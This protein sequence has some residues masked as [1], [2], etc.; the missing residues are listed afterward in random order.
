MRI[1]FYFLLIGLCLA[2][3][4][5]AQT[6]NYQVYSLF[7]INI[8]KYSSWPAQSDDFT[9]TVFG[10]SKVYDELMKQ[11]GKNINGHI[12]RVSQVDEITQIGQPNILYISDNKS[13]ALDDV[14][15]MT[16]GK[17]ILSIAER[18]GLFKK[19]AGFSFVVLDNGTLR[20]DINASELEKRQIKV[21]K[22]L[23]AL[24]NSYL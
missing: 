1:R 7:V 15:K 10:K 20:Y 11:N 24:A 3:V 6:T 13:S 5:Y 23:S 9:I 12:I 22:T 19:G 18:E 8:A 2:S 21:A 14:Q 17:A 16:Q 4:S